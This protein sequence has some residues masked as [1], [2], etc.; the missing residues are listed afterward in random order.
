MI[1]IVKTVDGNRYEFQN[2]DDLEEVVEKF[3]EY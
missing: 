1:L 3:G 2:K